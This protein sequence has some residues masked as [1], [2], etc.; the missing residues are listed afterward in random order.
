MSNARVG[1]YML[2]LNSH[3]AQIGSSGSELLCKGVM[4][5]CEYIV[6]HVPLYLAGFKM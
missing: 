6:P 4:Y 1:V 5:R 3:G 2:V